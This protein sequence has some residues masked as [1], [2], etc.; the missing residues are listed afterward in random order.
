[1]HLFA[2]MHSEF[3]DAAI[4]NHYS[5]QEAQEVYDLI[6]EFANY[7]F[8]RSHSI[9]YAM[10]AYQMMYWSYNKKQYQLD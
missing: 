2:K 5:E 4:A 7:G 8:N 3:I 10:I 9:A 1:M 6:I